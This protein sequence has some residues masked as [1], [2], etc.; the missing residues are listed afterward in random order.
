MKAELSEIIAGF[1]AAQIYDV[2]SGLNFLDGYFTAITWSMEKDEWKAMSE[3]EKRKF[4][5]AILKH[6]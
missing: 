3:E 2:D 1:K 6:I 4:V 5:Q